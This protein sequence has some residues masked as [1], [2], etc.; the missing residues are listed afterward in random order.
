MQRLRLHRSLR[1]KTFGLAV[2]LAAAALTA[3]CGSMN[4]VSDGADANLMLRGHDPVAYFTVGMPVRGGP[5]IETEHRGVTYRFAS[6]ENRRQFM[7][8]RVADVLAHRFAP[9][10]QAHHVQVG[11]R[12]QGDREKDDIGQ[13]ALQRPLK[14]S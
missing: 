4:V 14:G 12:D 11:G 2:L 1:L 5:A 6:E 9:V 7:W 10:R 8:S 13:P 3:G